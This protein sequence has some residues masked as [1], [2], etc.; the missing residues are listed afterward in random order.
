MSSLEPLPKTPLTPQQIDEHMAHADGVLGAAGHHVN[1]P[2]TREVMRR[3]L[4]GELT[5]DQAI[6]E[7]KA[8]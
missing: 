8:V 4:V 1:D 3:Y 5:I 6:A 7:I 2:N